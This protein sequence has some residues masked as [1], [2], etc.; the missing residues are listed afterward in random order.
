MLTNQDEHTKGVRSWRIHRIGWPPQSCKGKN[1]GAFWRNWPAREH[2]K[3]WPKQMEAEV[4][5]FV[6]THSGVT[7][8]EGAGT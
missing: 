1:Q 7:D 4:A 8:E 5:E 6:E 3:C 2:G